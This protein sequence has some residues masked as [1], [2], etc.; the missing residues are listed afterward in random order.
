M[1]TFKL[2]KTIP[3]VFLGIMCKSNINIQYKILNAGAYRQFNVYQP[4][5]KY[6]PSVYLSNFEMYRFMAGHAKW[7]NVKHVKA[8]KDRQKSVLFNKYVRII[9]A[10]IRGKKVV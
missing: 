1:I 3:S 8:E 10:A 2:Y 6:K 7:Q 9:N 4:S 5:V